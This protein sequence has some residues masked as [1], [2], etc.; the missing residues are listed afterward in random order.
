MRTYIPNY[1]D[2][3]DRY[4]KTTG[5]YGKIIEKYYNMDVMRT[6][7]QD[8]RD[9]LVDMKEPVNDV[10]TEAVIQIAIDK[11]NRR[12]AYI[13]KTINELD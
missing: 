12:I 2:I 6:L 7:F 9:E 4:A 1:N 5:T 8:L 10:M 11:I 3:M 13:N